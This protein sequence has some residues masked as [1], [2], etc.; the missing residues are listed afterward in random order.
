MPLHGLVFDCDA[1]CLQPGADRRA[2]DAHIE[3]RRLQF[4]GIIWRQLKAAQRA[5]WTRLALERD[6]FCD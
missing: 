3:I 6:K 4:G 2:S 1:V 5:S